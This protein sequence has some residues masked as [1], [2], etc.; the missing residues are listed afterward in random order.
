M[1]K[2]V[3]KASILF[4]LIMFIQVKIVNANTCGYKE[5]ADLNSLAEKIETK[6]EI[7]KRPVYFTIADP[8]TGEL[9]EAEGGSHKLKVSVYNIHP[10]TYVI[11]T[12]TDSGEE[13]RINYNDTNKGVYTYETNDLIEIK[14]YKYVVYANKSE[15][16]KDTPLKTYNISTPKRNDLH[17]QVACEGM[18]HLEVCKEFVSEEFEFNPNDLAN[19]IKKYQSE[20]EIN[21][22][23][24]VED[25]LIQKVTKNNTVTI[26]VGLI[27][28]LT[29]VVIY[30]VIRRRRYE[31]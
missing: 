7:V 28:I 25:S 20:D 16:C 11:Q 2:K 14:N 23:K 27:V 12:D 29:G 10:D 15:D 18:E 1:I 5:I 17:T 3:L 21:P 6:Y 24:V 4:L 19:E 30:I 31:L 26:T 9:M 22:P 8:E 13:R